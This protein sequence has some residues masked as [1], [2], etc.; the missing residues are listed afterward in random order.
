VLGGGYALVV[1]GL[2]Q[3]LGRESSLAVAAATLA[4]AGM[5]QPAHRRIQQV[6]DRRFN[7]RRYDA[8]Q[9]IAAFSE[10][11]RQQFDLETVT[12]GLLA[13]AEHTMQP[14]HKS[15]WLKPCNRAAV[16]TSPPGARPEGTPRPSDGRRGAGRHSG[17]GRPRNTGKVPA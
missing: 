10:R 4:V 3:F 15:L 8:A 2:G 7:R 16:G 11:V 14:T 6:V 12:T 13:L 17:G 1:V 5:V 9:T